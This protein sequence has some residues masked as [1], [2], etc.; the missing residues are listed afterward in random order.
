[1]Y[2]PGLSVVTT[3]TTAPS[4]AEVMTVLM[5][6]LRT[7][8]YD[9]SE[10]IAPA[11]WYVLPASMLASIVTTSSPFKFRTGLIGITIFRGVGGKLG[12]GVGMGV[13]AGDG[14]LVEH[15]SVLQARF[16]A[17]G[18]SLPP[19]AG[20]WKTTTLRSCMPP[21]QEASQDAHGSNSWMQSAGHFCSLHKSRRSSVGHGLPPWRAGVST[22]LLLTTSPPPHSAEHA[23]QVP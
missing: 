5:S 21:P 19:R 1:M 20:S 18:H 9:E 17:V 16:S 11:S 14:G 23:P 15:R 22:L 12:V 13:L 8:P 4:L 10:H 6:S 7:T 3:L 2:S